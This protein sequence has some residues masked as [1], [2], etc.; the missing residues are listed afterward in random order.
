[1][2]EGRREPP[3]LKPHIS[4]TAY[5]FCPFWRWKQKV[6]N[7]DRG[8][9][10]QKALNFVFWI[11]DWSHILDFAEANSRTFVNTFG[12]VY[13]GHWEPRLGLYLLS[14]AL[15]TPKQLR[16]AQPQLAN[17][18]SIMDLWLAWFLTALPLPRCL[19]TPRASE[20]QDLSTPVWSD[21]MATTHL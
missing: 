21:Q 20:P 3:S 5:I 12:A 1:M 8:V 18:C 10:K 4:L 9:K 13:E 16:Q 2:G 11:S 7:K 14:A 19:G 6:C 17:C 15:L